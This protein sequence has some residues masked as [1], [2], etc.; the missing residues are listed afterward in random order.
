MS[1][2]AQAFFTLVGRHLVSLMFFPVRHCLTYFLDYL[3]FFL[4]S[5]TKLFAGLNEGM[6]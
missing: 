5:V 2:L 4:T 6:L 3:T 1:I